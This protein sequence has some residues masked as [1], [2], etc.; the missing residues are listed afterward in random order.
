MGD[1]GLLLRHSNLYDAFVMGY[2]SMGRDGLKGFKLGFRENSLSP[3]NF[4]SAILM[5]KTPKQ[6]YF[7]YS[8]LSTNLTNYYPQLKY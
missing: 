8:Q 3:R 6:I 5:V 4:I 7:P 2:I 1:E